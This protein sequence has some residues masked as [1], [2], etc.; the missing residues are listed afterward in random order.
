[1]NLRTIKITFSAIVLFFIISMIG[2]GLLIQNNNFYIK[3]KVIPEI[4]Y[5]YSKFLFLYSKN[6]NLAN[7]YITDSNTSKNST[8]IR[9]IPI[10]LY[11]GIASTP[12]RFNMTQDAFRD[13]MFALK[14]AG[15]ET[16]KLD[17]LYQF[18]QGKKTL[19]EKS[20][21]LTFDDARTDS[22]MGADP[23]LKTLDYTAVMFV[24]TQDSLHKKKDRG[25][26]Y[27][28]V[29]DLKSMINFGRWEIGSH[30]KQETGDMVQIE[31]SGT[32]AN[33]LSNKMWI[34]NESRLETDEEY[35]ARIRTELA[36]SKSE[37]ENTFGIKINAFAYPSSDYGQQAEN[38]PRAVSVIS[39][40]MNNN[41]GMAF[42]QVWQDEGEYTSN[43]PGADLLHLKRI[44]SGNDWSGQY[45]LNYLETAKSKGLPYTDNYSI[46]RGWKSSWGSISI[47]DNK[48]NIQSASTTSG[49]SAILDGTRDWE[50]YFYFMDLNWKSGSSLT[51]MSRLKDHNN[52]LYCTFNGNSVTIGKKIN[53]E[54][55]TLINVKD[56]IDSTKP[57]IQLGMSVSGT[58][59][60]CYEGS[61]I[62]AYFNNTDPS[63]D[64]GGIG[65]QIWDKELGK[66]SI[67]VSFV[68]VTDQ[69]HSNELKLLLT[70]YPIKKDIQQENK[71]PPRKEKEPN[72]NMAYISSSVI[73]AWKPATGIISFS[74]TS[75]FVNSVT[76]NTTA[77]VYAPGG[78]EWTDYNF[79]I[80]VAGVLGSKISV[81]GRYSDSKNYAVCEYIDQGSFVSLV[82][83]RNGNRYLMT[84]GNYNSLL[85]NTKQYGSVGIRARGS[86]ISCLRNNQVMAQAE[87]STIQK[88]GTIGLKV[89]AEAPGY[90]KME[91]TNVSVTPVFK[92]IS[93]E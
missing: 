82:E 52:Y 76:P 17:D 32:K 38:N 30:A 87:I 41:Y 18:M 7:A 8:D 11:H 70:N 75:M 16:I 53:G 22:Y 47:N 86:S 84:I 56:Q 19:P 43:Y 51:L 13:Q 55:K 29:S 60:Q 80:D 31:P 85:L 46:D 2:S 40:N 49:G 9:D 14:H 81:I 89:Y 83:V 28:G 92:N 24:P 77:F 64:R 21:L 67:S 37:L 50:D 5:L 57:D 74:G 44:E 62:V 65:I 71:I 54:N 20:F 25:G 26:Y 59:V 48:L 78:Y 36:D 3:D 1:M 33:F 90:T 72:T 91:T 4:N 6:N 34:T 15:Y 39:R 12:G 73:D 61:H 27:L 79:T 93:N 66:S 88:S 35:D 63:L 42:E 23:I 45:L 10:L 68:K 69:N 58:T